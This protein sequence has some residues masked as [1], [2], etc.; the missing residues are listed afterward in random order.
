MVSDPLL[1]AN[2]EA[3]TNIELDWV[4]PSETPQPFPH[5]FTLTGSHKPP[6][7]H[8]RLVCIHF[9]E[10]RQVCLNGQGLELLIPF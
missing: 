4:H 5:L 6:D 2:Q 9:K 7:S 1:H 8:V 10:I 3:Q